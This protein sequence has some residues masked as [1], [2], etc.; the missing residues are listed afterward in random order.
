MRIVRD[1]WLEPPRIV[2]LTGAGISRESG[3][4]TFRDA[5][6]I[7]A[8]V[9]LEEVATPEAFVR[10]PARVQAFYNARRR[11]LQHASVLPN[12]AHEALARL[13]A[14]RPGEVLIATQNIDDLHERAGSRA[15]IHMHGELLK[16]RC[17]VC[18]KVTLWYNDLTGN[19]SCP[20]CAIEGRLRP[21]VVWF[22][23][24]PLRLDEIYQALAQC[25]M[26][27]AIGTSGTVEPAASFVEEA[28]RAGAHTVEL[29]LEA[30][31]SAA[32]FAERVYGPATRIVP[33]YV[34]QLLKV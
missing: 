15:V 33:E 9:R 17:T 12:A 27:I 34:A 6:G 18:S 24:I 20:S 26:F 2:I 14:V 3:L 5:D 32:L 8:S 1:L 25:K 29:N 10:D 28:R 11:Q 22:G 21:H 23:E 4:A 31:H 7:W 13:E 16:A 30:S 19:E